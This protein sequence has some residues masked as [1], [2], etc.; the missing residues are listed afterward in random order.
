[1]GAHGGGSTS[2]EREESCDDSVEIQRHFNY[3]GIIKNAMR[4]Q[5][6]PSLSSGLG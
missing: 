6:R 2:E 3:Y 5:I 4:G 1:M